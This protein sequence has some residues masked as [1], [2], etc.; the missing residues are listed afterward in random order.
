MSKYQAVPMLD[1]FI[2]RSVKN[3]VHELNRYRLIIGI[4]FACMGCAL[5]SSIGITVADLPLADKQMGWLT[6]SFCFSLLIAIC[7]YI[8][9]GKPQ[10]YQI[11]G[12]LVVGL[13]CFTLYFGLYQSGGPSSQ[14]TPMLIL[15]PVA[16]FFLLGSSSGW[17]WTT[18][19][20]GIYGFL[21]GI[22][23]NGY[24]FP[25][26]LESNNFFGTFFFIYSFIVVAS[27]AYIY[28]K[29]YRSQLNYSEKQKKKFQ[30]L[31]LHDPL[32]KLANRK[33][34][35]ETFDS[36]LDRA[37]REK[38]SSALLVIDLDHFK[39]LNDLHGHQV[40]DKLLQH[41]AD[42]L[43]SNIRSSDL[44]A[45]LGGDEF[46]VI[47]EHVTIQD[48][49]LISDKILSSVNTKLQFNISGEVLVSCSIGVAISSPKQGKDQA[50]ELYDKADQAL[51]K[52]KKKRNTWCF[53]AENKEQ[54]NF[55]TGEMPAI[56]MDTVK[57][58][59]KL[60]KATIQS[61]KQT[62]LES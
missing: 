58:E 22:E 5:V 1:A 45:R 61:T 32:T 40:G 33:L 42:K 44:A 31:A 35:D 53:L 21:F 20:L 41:V 38:Y 28:E 17:G 2:P 57:L 4:A 55:F 3:N 59:K 52:A 62:E 47:L 48:I 46:A 24:Q 25:N 7:L 9:T 54:N 6:C 27:L 16:A 43:K 50:K 19:A 12:H 39:P 34:F 49:S 13:C 8:R 51:Y 36:A 56:D 26:R 60:K 14:L 10:S 30:Y 29:L 18:L 23:M 37:Q 11:S 15:T